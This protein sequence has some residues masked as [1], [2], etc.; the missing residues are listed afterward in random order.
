MCARLDD[1]V[2][3]CECYQ[4]GFALGSK[5]SANIQ[6]ELIRQ[7][8]EIEQAKLLAD[9]ESWAKNMHL[10]KDKLEEAKSFLENYKSQRENDQK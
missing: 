2:M 10:L 8:R 3:L 5:V 9:V 1:E 6:R 4:R 7:E